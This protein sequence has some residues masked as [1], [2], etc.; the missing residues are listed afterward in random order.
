MLKNLNF[1]LEEAESSWDSSRDRSRSTR[2][3]LSS[4]EEDDMMH[5][6]YVDL[7]VTSHN[8]CVLI[9]NKYVLKK[10]LLTNADSF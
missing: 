4:Q 7:T 10:P 1:L 9:Q 2:L 8:A 3:L 5:M 6:H